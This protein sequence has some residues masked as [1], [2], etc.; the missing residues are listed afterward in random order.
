[1]LTAS[2]YWSDCLGIF[3]LM[4]QGDAIELLDR[5]TEKQAI[6]FIYR[7]VFGL[8]FAELAK[9]R[10]LSRQSYYYFLP[11]LTKICAE[12][13][14]HQEAITAIQELFKDYDLDGF[15]VEKDCKKHLL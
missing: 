12:A 5:L 9:H 1:M 3:N 11:G 2:E 13:E 14:Q 8:S 4:T 15:F 7:F 10:K 6:I